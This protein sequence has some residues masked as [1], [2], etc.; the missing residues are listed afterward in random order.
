MKLAVKL[1]KNLQIG[2]NK[3]NQLQVVL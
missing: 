3:Q 1:L 2:F